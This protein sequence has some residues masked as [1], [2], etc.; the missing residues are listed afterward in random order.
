MAGKSLNKKKSILVLGMHRS[1]TSALT[2][3]IN[4]LGVDIG[5]NLME[6]KSDNV[7]GF[8]EEA[9]I[10]ALNDELLAGFG[11]R[12]D[13]IQEFPENWFQSKNAL[14][15][16]DKILSTL[17]AEFGNSAVWG[18]KDPR[19][20]RLLPVYLPALNSAN[21]DVKA[22]MVLRDPMEVALSLQ[23][24][25]NMPLYYGLLL[26]IRYIIDSERN[27]RKIKRVWFPLEIL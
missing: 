21:V 15:V 12:W 6:A 25:E 14:A 8:W 23:A 4:L 27:S 2:R 7:K 20:C 3:V 10:V 19:L 13:D 16:K 9:D 5:Q 18:L 24:R 11:Q 22:I 1:G 26:W 17:M